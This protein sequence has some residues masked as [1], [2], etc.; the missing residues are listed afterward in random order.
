MQLRTWRGETIT[1]EL[2]LQIPTSARPGSY[3]LHVTDAAAMNALEQ[4]ELRQSFVPRDL[5]QLLRALNALR[6]SHHVYAR[7]V[8]AEDGAVV[9]GEL[10]P[11][12]PSSVLS[13]LGSADSGGG[14]VPVRTV[15]VWDHDLP[16]EHV[17]TGSRSLPVVIER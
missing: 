10:L 7:L 6:K 4:R 3:T 1:K 13:V 9:A 16:T 5:D 11:S 2:P 12:L 14:V 8:R 17:V 15:S